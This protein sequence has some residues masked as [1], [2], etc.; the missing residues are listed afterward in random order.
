MFLEVCFQQ[1]EGKNCRGDA[2]DNIHRFVKK[3]D[4]A[5]EKGTEV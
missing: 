4:K 2:G 5:L 1:K 3:R